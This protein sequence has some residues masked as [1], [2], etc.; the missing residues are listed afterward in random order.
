MSDTIN[1]GTFLS[2]L[3]FYI[4]LIT[5][6]SKDNDG[7]NDKNSLQQAKS[8]YEKYSRIEN[9]QKHNDVDEE[10]I[11]KCI[12]R[13]NLI[14][15]V[16]S[17]GKPVN[18]K[19]KDNQKK[20]LEFEPCKAIKTNDPHDLYEYAKENNID[21]LTGISLEFV[22]RDTISEHGKLSIGHELP[23]LYTK[24]LF[25]ISQIVLCNSS[26][27]FPEEKRKKIQDD[28]MLILEDV[29]S[30]ITDIEENIDTNKINAINGLFS[31][32]I[33]ENGITPENLA[34]AKDDM[35][36]LFE[37]KG[38]T[39]DSSMNKMI[40]TISNNL[41]GTDFSGGNLLNNMFGIAEK[42]AKEMQGDLQ[43]D[44]EKFQQ[45]ISIFG[46][47]FKNLLNDPSIAN[48]IPTEFRGMIDGLMNGGGMDG[49]VSTSEEQIL[50]AVNNMIQEKGLNKEEVYSNIVD[51]RGKVDIRKLQE[52][53]TVNKI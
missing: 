22:L 15:K 23:W 13:L 47:M 6:N 48:D 43:A 8:L 46:D 26:L 41:Q 4:K 14:L 30:K 39:L 7:V 44:P 40:D 34:T 9:S 5:Y 33:L 20:I 18:I 3:T 12:K 1:I 32:N 53:L 29:F 16:D 25:Y 19:N 11:R 24:S 52:Y 42:V 45:N 31:T 50:S 10:N 36:D 2:Q 49:N 17:T 27:N 35:K 38:L 51:T 21:I 28:S 37:T